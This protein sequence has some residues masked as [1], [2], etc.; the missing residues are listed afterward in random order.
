MRQS[1]ICPDCGSYMWATRASCTLRQRGTIR[2]LTGPTRPRGSLIADNVKVG[3]RVRLMCLCGHSFTTTWRWA[4]IARVLT[5][6]DEVR[7][8]KY[9]TEHDFSTQLIATMF[10][11]SRSAVR[12][13]LHRRGVTPSKRGQRNQSPELHRQ[14]KL[15]EYLYVDQGMLLK[16]IAVL[17]GV[18]PGTW[19]SRLAIAGIPRRTRSETNRLSHARRK[20]ESP[21]ILDA[22][23]A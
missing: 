17:T 11:I 5:V 2:P 9:Y 7:V 1:P 18:P 13:A 10:N 4:T 23:A 22:L 14:L 21:P 12:D 8:V 16:E 6:E 20:G 3:Q 15:L 19:R